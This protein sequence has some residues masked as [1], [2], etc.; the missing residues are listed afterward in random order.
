MLILSKVPLLEDHHN[1][2]L[3]KLAQVPSNVKFSSLVGDSCRLSG[4]REYHGPN[5]FQSSR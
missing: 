1:S 4:P 2:K 5:S 3:K